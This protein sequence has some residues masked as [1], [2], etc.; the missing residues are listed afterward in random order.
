MTP[1]EAAS[2]GGEDGASPGTE[3]QGFQLP[4]LPLPGLRS[5]LRSL[6]P[7]LPFSLT[8][9]P[10][11]RLTLFWLSSTAALLGISLLL[12]KVLCIPMKLWAAD[13]EGRPI[14]RSVSGPAPLGCACV[15]LKASWP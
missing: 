10:G 12:A 7:G 13:R 8:D 14:N 6:H 9:A 1:K 2:V 4:A 15:T 3:R 5:W 11:S